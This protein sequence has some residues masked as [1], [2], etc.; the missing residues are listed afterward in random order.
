MHKKGIKRYHGGA[1]AGDGSGVGLGM[2]KAYGCRTQPGWRK[3]ERGRE[4]KGWGRQVEME[5]DGEQ[6]RRE[7]RDKWVASSAAAVA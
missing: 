3:K 1:G 7:I 5:M 4:R 6:A 2:G